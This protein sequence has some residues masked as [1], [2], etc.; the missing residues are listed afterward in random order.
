MHLHRPELALVP[1]PRFL[2][3]HRTGAFR[4]DTGTGLRLG[5]GTEPAAR[6]LRTL[7][8]PATGL[9]LPAAADGA[10]V[11]VLD[12]ALS[13]LGEEGYGLT[14][15]PHRVLLR[16]ARPAGLLRGVQTVR[17]LLPPQ[18]LAAD[19][20]PGVEWA[21]PCVEISDV[22]RHPWRGAMLDVARH[23]QPVSYLR[24]YVDLLALHKL[25]V[26]HL[27]LTDDQGWRMPVAAH[28]RLT[29]IG[30]HRAE[31]MIGPS[32]STR[33]DGTP[34]G[35]AYTAAELRELVAYAAARGVTVVPEIEMPGHVRAALAAYP[36]LGNDPGST[37]DVWTRWGVCENTLGVSDHVLD[38]F[39]TVLDETME[40]FPSEHVHIGGDECP[41][42]EWERSPAALDRVRRE[43][44]AGPGALHPWFMQRMTDH[45]VR[46]GRRPVAWAENGTTLPEECTVMSWREPA[47]AWAAARR[48]QHV[49]F[50]D[51]RATYFDY[52][53]EEG[54]PGLLAQSG[55]VVDLPAVHGLD[56]TPPGDGA[57]AADRV[58]GASGQLWT[59]LVATPAHIEYLVYPR[60]CALADR[61]WGG[62]GDYADFTARLD[63]HRTR[64]DALE[65]PHARPPFA[66]AA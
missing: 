1:R 66:T 28:P 47:H 23:F 4:L 29:E 9:P 7:L 52:A 24:R 16:A 25:N 34:H 21:L 59:E 42:T 32:R 31:S 48:G 46:A 36:E 12:P 11:L 65:V 27:H 57:A 22:P 62:A 44:L 10:F 2:S 13:G 56:L 26:F 55:L 15:S 53:R 5:P 51:H 8:A 60:L 35:G 39:R 20:Q 50:A 41:T 6:L 30:G 54:D 17:Q 45:L 49:V 14:V 63:G 40:I 64:L 33:Y 19:P 61:V 58:L 43:G 38:F 37:L 3:A 18:A